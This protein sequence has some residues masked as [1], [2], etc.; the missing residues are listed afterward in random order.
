MD[1]ALELTRMHIQAR[2]NNLSQ[3]IEHHSDIIV[4]SMDEIEV[5]LAAIAMMHLTAETRQLFTMAHDLGVQ[6]TPP[7]K[8]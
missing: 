5:S 3:Q 2:V 7:F 1:K 6:I 4:Q 8:P